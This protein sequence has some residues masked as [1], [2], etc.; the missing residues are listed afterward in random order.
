MYVLTTTFISK[1]VRLCTQSNLMI[2]R[3]REVTKQL[4]LRAEKA[5]FK[6][7]VLTVDTP[8]FGIRRADIRNKFTLPSHLR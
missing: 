2:V 1:A 6:A 3:L 5:G 8:L 4:V 7:I